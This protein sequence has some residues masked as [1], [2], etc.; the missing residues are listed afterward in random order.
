[1][2]LAALDKL[3]QKHG[4]NTAKG[5]VSALQSLKRTHDGYLE[6]MPREDADRL[7]RRALQIIQDNYRQQLQKDAGRLRGKISEIGKP[8]EK[9]IQETDTDASLERERIRFHAMA[10][11]E[12]SAEA[13]EIETMPPEILASY[14]ASHLNSLAGEMRNRGADTEADTL[15]AHLVRHK[16]DAGEA[17]KSLEQVQQ[18]QAEI[19]F[20]EGIPAGKIQIQGAPAMDFIEL[21]G[22]PTETDAMD[23]ARQQAIITAHERKKQRNA[24]KRQVAEAVQEY[25]H[26]QSKGKK[27]KPAAEPEGVEA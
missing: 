20:M 15:R 6:R 11:K 9:H 7:G 21:A 18:L 19:D 1:M 14:P 26:E 22:L 10:T 8:Y 25:K 5:A 23:A 4:S 24:M 16:V 12:L 27:R 2:D 3:A 17:W 13:R